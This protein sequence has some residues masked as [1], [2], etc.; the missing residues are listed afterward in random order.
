MIKLL[1]ID[2]EQ[3]KRQ[4][5]ACGDTLDLHQRVV[6]GEFHSYLAAKIEVTDDA[7]PLC[8]AT[9]FDCEDCPWWWFTG[10]DCCADAYMDSEASVI[11]LK[12]WIRLI[13]NE[14]TRRG[15]YLL[16]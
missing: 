16:W 9:C 14:L 10:G 8:V 7:C 12:E 5:A 6:D 11:R 13:T 4:L 15:G 1:T 3:L 2:T